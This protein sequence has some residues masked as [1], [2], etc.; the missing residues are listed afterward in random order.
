MTNSVNLTTDRPVTS[1]SPYDPLRASRVALLTTFRR[2]GVGIATP[3]EIHAV[4]DKA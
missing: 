2:S 3:V 1:P 4:E